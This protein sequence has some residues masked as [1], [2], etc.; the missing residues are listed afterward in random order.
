MSSILRRIVFISSYPP[1]HCGIASFTMSLVKSLNELSPDLETKVIAVNNMQ[2]FDY[3]ED[4]VFTISK[5]LKDDYTK[6]AEVINNISPD[7][8][9]LQHEFG[10]FHPIFLV[11]LLKRIKGKVVTVLHSIA[12]FRCTSQSFKKLCHL[13]NVI[14]VMINRAAL[15]LSKFYSVDNYKMGWFISLGNYGN[16]FIRTTKP[17]IAF[18]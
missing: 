2:N 18:L 16:T 14:T 13:S 10:L 7:I 5:N 12:P 9:C 15:I 3:N 4:V 8:I 11:N 6:A 1:R 17:H